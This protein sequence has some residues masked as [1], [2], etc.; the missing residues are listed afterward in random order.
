[1]TTLQKHSCNWDL[2]LPKVLFGY[3]CG[4]QTSTKFSP[5]MVL[6]GHT[7]RLK[8]N[9]QFC[10]LTQTL[11]EDMNIN[12]LTI[13]MISKTQLIYELHKSILSNNA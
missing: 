13:Q 5:F 10:M 4:I 1:M 11:D 7:H 12:Q 9:N 2:Y 3:R 8:A 6:I